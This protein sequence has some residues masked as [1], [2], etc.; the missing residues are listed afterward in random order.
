MNFKKMSG[1]VLI[2]LGFV[3]SATGAMA[4]SSATAN[5]TA[6]A[7]V[8]RPITLAASRDLAFGNVVPGVAAGTLA[9]AGTLAGLQT[10]AGGVTQ[11]GTQQ[12]TVTSAQ[13]DVTGESS[14]T[15]TITIPVAA[16]TINDAGV[17]T[18]TVDTWTSSIATTAGAGVLSGASP[19]LQTFYVGGMLHVAGGQAPGAYSGTF[20]VTV[21]YN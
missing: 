5:G 15:Y 12:G 19:G 7:N 20:S 1:R 21:A 8:V 4:Q 13:F 11:P 6:T 3:A 14:F 16:V 2:A 17:N 18:M 10:A 9:V